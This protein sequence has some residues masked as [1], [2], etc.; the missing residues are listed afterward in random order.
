MDSEKKTQD[1]LEKQLKELHD[2]YQDLTENLT[3]FQEKESEIL[4]KLRAYYDEQKVNQLRE[5]MTNPDKK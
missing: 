2:Q 5:S 4:Q 1:E 3:E